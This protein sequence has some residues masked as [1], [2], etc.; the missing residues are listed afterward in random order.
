MSYPAL[1]KHHLMA[2]WIH[3]T[4]LHE[5]MRRARTSLPLLRQL[6]VIWSCIVHS[7]SVFPMHLCLIESDNVNILSLSPIS[8]HCSNHG[9]FHCFFLLMFFATSISKSVSKHHWGFYS[10][11]DGFHPPKF[12]Q[13]L[14][15]YRRTLAHTHTL[16]C[17]SGL[18]SAWAV[19]HLIASGSMPL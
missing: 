19:R 8:V 17:L 5:H 4:S 18:L 10:G 2:S 15:N 9:L 3:M 13:F 16:Q 12:S 14:W 6:P 11:N 7:T 1:S